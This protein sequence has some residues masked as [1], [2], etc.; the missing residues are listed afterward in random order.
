MTR[1]DKPALLRRVFE[2]GCSYSG[3]ILSYQKM[4]GQLQDAGNTTTLAHYLRLLA[5]AGLVTG[6][7]KYSGQK[8]RQRASSPKL[9]ACN[10]ALMSATAH[11]TFAEARRFEYWG[12]V[13]ETAGGLRCSTADR[14]GYACLLLGCGESRGRFRAAAG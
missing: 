1:I 6:L 10:T 4:M 2:L 3:Q 9:L 5:G 11:L 8:V 14:T 13:V 7:S 12:R